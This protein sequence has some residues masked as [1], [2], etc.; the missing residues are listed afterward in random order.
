MISG[1]PEGNTSPIST[2]GTPAAT[3][4]FAS[5][6]ASSGATEIS[7]P[8]AV[9][10]S[11]RIVFTSSLIPSSYAPRTRRIRGWL[12]GLRECGRR[13]RIQARHR[14][15]ECDWHI[16]AARRWKP[17]RFRGRVRSSPK[18][19]TSV[20]ACTAKWSLV[21]RRWSLARP[22]AGPGPTLAGYYL[23]G[24]FVERGHGGD[25]GID[26]RLLRRFFLDR[27]RDHARP[28]RFGKN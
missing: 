24:F 5:L 11:N 13:E 21:V 6:V 2:A 23:C 17:A 12:S 3:R 16:G 14:A 27:G 18:P 8:P 19:V 7:K 26:P 15:A 25:R 1:L 4:A 28:Q 20:M 10:G 22:G 9:C